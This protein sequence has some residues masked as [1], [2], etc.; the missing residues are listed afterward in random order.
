MIQGFDPVALPLWAVLLFAAAMFPLGLL[1]PGCP[2]CGGGNCGACGL[3]YLPYDQ[4][5]GGGGRM[6]CNGTL[7]AE[8][9]VRVTLTSDPTITLVTRGTGASYTRWTRVYNCS[10]AAGDYVVPKNTNTFLPEK[11]FW[12]YLVTNGYY[13]DVKWEITPE[14]GGGLYPAWPVWRLTA[15]WIL[16]ITGSERQQTCS[17]FPGPET[18]DIGVLSTN[19]WRDD[20]FGAGKHGANAELLARSAN[21]SQQACNPAPMLLEDE[22]RPYAFGWGLGGGVGCTYRVELV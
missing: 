6:C 3:S 5:P 16:N 7:A 19:N 21:Q 15:I 22:L 18:C 10:T 1:L 4:Q 11:C 14:E 13:G 20:S 9:T 17:G 2:C 8:V 12:R